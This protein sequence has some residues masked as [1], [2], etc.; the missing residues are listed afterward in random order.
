MIKL[1][2][3]SI[4]ILMFSCN[5][6]DSPGDPDEGGPS[7][8]ASDLNGTWIMSEICESYEGS[9]NDEYYSEGE[10]EG[11]N[12]PLGCHID[13]CYD[14]GDEFGV[15]YTFANDIITMC[16][17][18][19]TYCMD[20][21]RLE[22]GVGNSVSIC[23]IDVGCS[24]MNSDECNSYGDPCVVVED[25]CHYWIDE[26]EESE[27]N[28]DDILSESYIPDC[29]DGTIEL[30]DDVLVISQSDES[31]GCTETYER[32]FILFEGSSDDGGSADDGGDDGDDLCADDCPIDWI[33]DGDCDYE[34]NNEACNW[35]DGD[36]DGSGDDDGGDDGK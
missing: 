33:G 27:D 36:C 20:A 14:E 17:L 4:S 12:P 2:L 28:S 6:G 1:I 21:A 16:T 31:D 29:S 30:S 13:Q 24:E 19:G 23:D 9:C 25:E 11:D 15:N 32:T 5:D 10:C 34:C 26:G 8:Q 22:L 7:I 18:T 35:D 3:F